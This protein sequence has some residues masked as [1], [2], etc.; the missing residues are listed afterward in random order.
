MKGQL[1]LVRLQAILKSL[2]SIDPIL[3][4]GD[5]G[6]DK[7]TY[8]EVRRISPEAPVPV[9]EV[10][11]EWH[12]LG[13]AANVV[14]NFC[15]LKIP[16][17]ICGIVGEDNAGALFEH[18][19]EEN[20]I[21]TWGV[22]RSLGR[23]TTLKE[24]VTTKT[25]QI[26]RID[27]EKQNSLTAAEESKVV[28]RIKDLIPGHSAVLI[29]DYSKGIITRP[30]CQKILELS[31]TTNTQKC[32]VGVDPGRETPPD[33]YYGVDLIKPN[34]N[35]AQVM[36]KHFGAFER[37]AEEMAPLISEKLNIKKVVITL[38][39]KGMLCFDAEKGG[40]MHTIPT[41]ARDV[42]DV[43]GAGD[44]TMALL[45]S[46]LVSGASLEESAWVANLGAGVV[47]GKRGT[48]TVT[49]QEI[50]DFWHTW[51]ET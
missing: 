34:F 20:H 22:V 24:R 9:V 15:A 17:N 36:C 6:V 26:C 21:K 2:N 50:L 46:A 11:K 13:L 28:F 42:Y 40:A 33:F 44:T 8:G 4:V 38:G 29:S 45:M 5:L 31:K 39:S 30:V 27:Y 10:E 1:N 37:P 18:L 43:S 19:L 12:K 32:L 35:E 16:S 47:V 7:Y 14:D 41:L 51:K 25:Q 49:D 48:A 23:S 3:V